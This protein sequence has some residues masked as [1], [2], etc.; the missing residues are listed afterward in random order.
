MRFVALSIDEGN[1][2][3][4]FCPCLKMYFTKNKKTDVFE[5]PLVPGCSCESPG[6]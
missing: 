3:Y 6:E 1:E 4:A 2:E 5:I